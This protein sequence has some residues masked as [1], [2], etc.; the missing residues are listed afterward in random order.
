MVAPVRSGSMPANPG[1]GG[2]LDGPTAAMRPSPPIHTTPSRWTVAASSMVTTVPRNA[3]MVRLRFCRDRTD[4]PSAWGAIGCT[5][6]TTGRP[7]R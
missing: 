1:G 7:I 5:P 3:H 4:I 2:A 6:A